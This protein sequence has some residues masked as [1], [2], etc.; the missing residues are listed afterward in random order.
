MKLPEII[1]ATAKAGGVM[2]MA[3]AA[4][5]LV[6]SLVRGMLLVFLHAAMPADGTGI[7]SVVVAFFCCIT[8]VFYAMANN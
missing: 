6:E 3:G 1:Q 8:A 4:G 2:A 5:V 7:I